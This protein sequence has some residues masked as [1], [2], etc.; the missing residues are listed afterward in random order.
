VLGWAAFKIAK[1]F[2]NEDKRRREAYEYDL[3]VRNQQAENT[4]RMQRDATQAL[5]DNMDLTYGQDYNYCLQKIREQKYPAVYAK[6]NTKFQEQI[7]AFLYDE[8]LTP[9]QRAARVILVVRPIK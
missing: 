4:A 8:T 6:F 7:A 1:Y 5:L 3:K 2:E 9:E